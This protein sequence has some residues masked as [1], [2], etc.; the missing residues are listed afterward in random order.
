MSIFTSGFLVGV[1]TLLPFAIF[2]GL[3]GLEIAVSLI[4][5]YV[6]CILTA[7]YIKDAIDLH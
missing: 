4:Q 7:S 1:L 2:V 5:A 6:F 3:V